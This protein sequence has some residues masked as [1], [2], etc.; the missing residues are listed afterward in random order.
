MQAR[1]TYRPDIDGLRALAILPVLWFHSDIR[2]V[3]GGFTGVD[4]FFVISGY[5][6]TLIIHREVSRR[7][8]TFSHF[9]KRRL[10]RIAPA[11]LVVL[12]VVTVAAYMLL[13]PYELVEYAHSTIAAMSMVSN[14]YFWK[15]GGYFTLSEAITP[16][17]HTWSLGIEEQFYL[18]FP[19]AVIVAE[20]LRVVKPMV[21]IL[22][23]LSFGLSLIMT[24][25]SPAAAFYL[26]PTRSWELM[27]GAALAVDLIAVPKRH[28]GYAGI[29]GIALL[30]ISAF[31]ISESDPFPSWRAIIPALG[32]AL[33]IGSPPLALAGRL[34]SH[35]ALVY[36]G[37][38]SYSLYLWHWPVFVFL[39]HLSAASSLT[40]ALA[41]FGMGLSFALAEATYKLVEQPARHRSVPF[42][43]VLLACGATA[44]IVLLSVGL[45]LIGR[46]VPERFAPPIVRMANGHTLHAPL[47]R[48][49]T[50]IGFDAALERC[51]IGPPG[52]ARLLLIGD[53]HAA[54]ISEAVEIATHQPGLVLSMGSCAPAIGWIHPALRGRDPQTCREFKR[55]SLSRAEGDRS[56]TTVVLSAYWASAER[57]GGQAFWPSVQRYADR[58]T[59]RG[60]RVIIVAGIPEPSV[61]VPW[62]AAIRLR[63]HRP[64]LKLECA[65]ARVPLERVTIVDVAAG[66]CRHPVSAL[67]TDGNHISRFAGK[68]IIAPALQNALRN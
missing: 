19:A 16:L 60:K 17:L 68:A 35:P 62:A 6:I 45:A 8:F 46:G 9:Y 49:C 65:S 10:R 32:A 31:A 5:L 43:K 23:V 57:A 26:L 29:C 63:F 55:R 3:P 20:R 47:A 22:A 2:G 15:T 48:T 54:A 13:L 53:S 56:I 1:I 50:D 28:S 7:T 21:A 33:V 37:R 25:R 14:V 18:L 41:I 27:I 34:L 59:S 44:A 30:L 38:R 51:H 24:P 64:S 66:F 36:M 58:L 42:S 39:R 11:F 52:N 67:F 4:T 12:S 40:P 61:D